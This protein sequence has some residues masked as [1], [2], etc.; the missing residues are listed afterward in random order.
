[1]VNTIIL[2]LLAGL[3]R[4]CFSDPLPVPQLMPRPIWTQPAEPQP[5]P[6]PRP[7]VHL[8][9]MGR[10]CTACAQLE[11][12]IDTLCAEGWDIWHLSV[13][14]G[15]HADHNARTASGW[16]V[17]RFPTL[18][19]VQDGHELSRREGRQPIESLREWFRKYHCAKRED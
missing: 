3:P 10:N 1:M 12:D 19:I 18:L 5:T 6:A 9:T 14:T 11:P 16:S 8:W 17:T 2:L 7:V 4:P 13:N 15:P